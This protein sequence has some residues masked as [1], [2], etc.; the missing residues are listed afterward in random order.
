MQYPIIVSDLRMASYDSMLSI[1]PEDGLMP[2][3]KGLEKVMA[4][5]HD[6]VI[7]QE[8]GAAFWA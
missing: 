6:V 7:R 1:E 3:R 5:L 8:I 2:S 4:I